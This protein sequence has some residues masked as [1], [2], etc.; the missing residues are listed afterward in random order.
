[1]AI[2]VSGL[3]SGMDTE[4]IVTQLVSAYNVKK[5]TYVKAQTKL[6]WK[7]DAWKTLNKKVKSLYSNIT[8]LKYS[9]AYKTKAATV[10][11][12]TKANVSA[13]STAVNGSYTLKINQV[14][15]SGYLTGGQL[16]SSTTGAT[17]LSELLGDD[18]FAG[19]KIEVNS[20]GKT[21]TIEVTADTTISDFVSKLNDAGVKAS[22]DATNQ[23]IYVA[24]SG[25]GAANDFSLA[26][27]DSNGSDALK[28]LGLS[29]ASKSNTERYQAWAAYDG[30]DIA[31]ILQDLQ[32]SKDA[33]STANNS[34]TQSRS[35]ISGYTAKVNYA[36]SYETM[37]NAYKGLDDAGEIR[38][39]DELASMSK[40]NLSKT[41]ALDEDG[42]F[43]RDDDGNLIE[44][45][46][47][48]AD[49]MK[50]TGTDRLNALAA[51]AGLVE[52]KDEDAGE[53]VKQVTIAEFAAAKKAVDKFDAQAA[54]DTLTEEEK[55]DMN[56]FI[57]TVQHAY[58]GTADSEYASIEELTTAY[59][60]KITEEQDNI[61]TQNQIISDNKAVLEKYA[62]LDNGE[63]QAALEARISYAVSQLSNAT[64]KT[65]YNTDAT[66]VDGQ[67]AEIYVNNAKYTSSSNSFSINGLKIEAL[68]STE[69][70]EINV[71]VKNDVD[72][73]YNKIKDFLKE[74]NSLINEMTSL[75]NADS[76]KGY[77]PLTTEEKDAMTDSE[78]EEWEKKVKSAL[79]RRD[80]TLGNLLNSMTSA[81][82][83]GY[84]VN[85]KTYSLSSFGIS[86][87]GYL[88]ADEN[89]ENAYHIDG[90]ADDSAVSSKTN[91]LKQML[92][93]DPDTVTSFM[94]QLVTGLYDE[95][96]AK[97]KSNTL[98]SA[99][100]VYNDKQMAKEYSNYTT[101]IKK[102]EDKITSMEDS[103]YKKFA[104]ME[105][106]LA[107][108][109]QSTSSLSGLLGS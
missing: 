102:W 109:Q 107:K 8:N 4:S 30:Q 36:S 87:L 73:V 96:D 72:G 88:N 40:A 15:K 46:D 80:D 39:L 79:L 86:T 59:N 12:T 21:S 90:D 50:A 60:D 43:K 89:E 101:T 13:E 34:I 27:A 70:S 104:A 24:A 49:D 33:I 93:E 57:T 95:I 55:A 52:K 20:A 11:D 98:S 3:A 47:T 81:M 92:Q 25:T 1:M 2:R 103:Y 32:N 29:V 31:Q 69:G 45:D 35:K 56:D 75:Y 97:M 85:G 77:E 9:S 41:Y 23:R 94:Q 99:M 7:Q 53:G 61:S 51:K 16:A 5:N 58:K 105:T 22:Y 63:D 28:A 14:A 65:Q 84:T 68:A 44:A 48:V 54:D 108:L 6:S 66:R 37:M 38:D 82:Y 19:G 83:K 67:D 62:L 78:V 42:N 76:A 106:A 74:Y 64:D 91:K 10:S 71:T 26:G 18:S 17:K 100:T